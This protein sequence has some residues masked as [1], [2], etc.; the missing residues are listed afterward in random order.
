M[1]SQVSEHL[2][3]K[4]LLFWCA[5]CKSHHQVPVGGKGWTWNGSEEC[6]TLTPSL[7]VNARSLNP[8]VPVCHSTVNDGMIQYLADSTHALSG[9]TLPLEEIE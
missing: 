4:Y 3:Q 2:G 9:Q 8:H 5:G 7:L 6:P 1:I